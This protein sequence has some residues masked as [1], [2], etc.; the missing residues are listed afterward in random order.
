[1]KTDIDNIT[2]VR[3]FDGTV[4]ASFSD[5]VVAS[6]SNALVAEQDGRPLFFFPLRDVYS[7]YLKR[8]PE[9][10]AG[11]DPS[12]DWW[13]V[14]AVGEGHAHAMWSLNETATE[15]GRLGEYGCF[16]PEVITIEASPREVGENSTELP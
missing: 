6:T 2:S 12:R 14:S 10:P 8:S 5:A 7:E 9:K 4:T 11:S 3:R 16:D 13:E 15:F 1:M